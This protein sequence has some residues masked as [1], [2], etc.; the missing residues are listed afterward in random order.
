HYGGPGSQV[1]V[2]RWEGARGLWQRWMAT[3]GYGAFMIDNEA[4]VAFGKRG[5]DRVHRSMGAL[6]LAG[7]L[8]GVA[9]LAAQEWADTGRLGLWG[10]SGGGFNTLYSILHR[11]GTWRAAVAGAPV[12]DWRSYDSIWTERYL[13]TPQSNPDGYRTSSPV[14]DAAA[15]ADALLV[16][17]GTAD[18]NVHPENT[19]ALVARLIE[20]GR[21]FDD[22]LYPGQK[23]SFDPAANRHF[24]QRMTEFFDRELGGGSEA[25]PGP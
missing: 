16:V 25:P 20:A 6:E 8:A 7:Q 17:H 15:L 14:H 9:A 2:D 12:S 13:D 4:S 10:W 18:D 1:V 5:E 11:P 22:A 21:R 24:F 19:T 23:H 3:R